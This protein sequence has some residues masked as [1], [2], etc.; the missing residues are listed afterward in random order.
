LFVIIS[1]TNDKTTFVKA[2]WMHNLHSYQPHIEFIK[3][4]KFLKL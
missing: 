3:F 4:I 2:F 1:L